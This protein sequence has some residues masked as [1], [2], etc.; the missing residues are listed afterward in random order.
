MMANPCLRSV[1]GSARRSASGRIGCRG[2]E[3]PLSGCK[4]LNV[5]Q[6]HPGWEADI[7]IEARD[8]LVKM[9][10]DAVP[11]G[12]LLALRRVDGA[13]RHRLRAARMEAAA[14]GRRQGARHL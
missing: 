4:R 11:R 3:R 7:L 14:G 8:R 2:S 13:A 6:I 1:L 5:R 9:T 10:R 12:N